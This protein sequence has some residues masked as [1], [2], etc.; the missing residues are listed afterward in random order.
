MGDTAALQV[1]IQ[2]LKKKIHETKWYPEGKWGEMNAPSSDAMLVGEKPSRKLKGH[3]GKVYA[4]HWAQNSAGDGGNPHA[5]VSASQDGKLIIWNAFTT[6]KFQAI[7]LRSSWV[8]TCAY[9]P[10][11]GLY[12]ACGGLDNLCS[13]YKVDSEGITGGGNSRDNYCELVKHDGYL[14]C[15]RFINDRKIITSSGDATC[16]LWDIEASGKR[17]LQHFTDHT[18]DCM[19]VAISPVDEHVF[20]SGSCDSMAKVWDT[21]MGKGEGSNADS[22][23]NC[24]MSFG[25]KRFPGGNDDMPHAHESDINSVCFLAD[26]MSIGTGSDDSSC[27]IFDMRS[28]G[29]INNFQHEVILHGITS[30][31]TS[32]TGRFFIAGYDDY[33]LR[34]F[35]TLKE[36]SPDSGTNTFQQVPVHENRVSSV[37]MAP[38]G[39]ALCTGSWDTLLHVHC[40]KA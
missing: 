1:E 22:S 21:R 29:I 3:F 35:D 26:G 18:G 32:K 23:G 10:T 28:Y 16:I 19:S 20:A 11:Q 27:K 6:N 40:P 7:P 39:K 13:V 4:L 37:G 36:L 25:E 24:V 30:V 38:S 8:M 2:D 31:C 33:H 34:I 9:E 14:S 15:C 17:D 12:V 5:L